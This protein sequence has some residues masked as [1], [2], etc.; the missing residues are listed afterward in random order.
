MYEAFLVSRD[1]ALAAVVERMRRIDF[2]GKPLDPS[3]RIKTRATTVDKLQRESARLTQIQDIAGARIVVD[4]GLDAQD[5]VAALVVDAF[6]GARIIDRRS[7]PSHGYRAVHV[8]V[9]YE[10]VPVEVQV[11]TQEQHQWAEI[12]ERLADQLGRGIRYGEHPADPHAAESVNAML[13]L[14]EF[15]SVTESSRLTISNIRE[16][17]DGIPDRRNAEWWDAL[18][19]D[20]QAG[21]DDRRRAAQARLAA[22]ELALK[23]AQDRVESILEDLRR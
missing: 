14:S 5:H 17:F 4:G 18:T 9:R 3:A 23:S 12:F 16:E 13:R 21:H 8:V 20:E 2:D 7:N 22:A 1:A 6:P 19:A 10:G 15:I 11:R